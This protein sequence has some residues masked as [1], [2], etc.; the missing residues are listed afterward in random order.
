MKRIALYFIRLLLGLY[1]KLFT[2]HMFLSIQ[3]KFD[4]IYTYWISN[5]LGGI[6]E[7]SIVYYPCKLEGGGSNRI[8]IG[9]HSSI[10]SHCILGCWANYGNKQTF[11]PEISIGNH[12]SIGEY[13]HI[14][15]CN[16][17]TLGD[18]VLTGR[19]VYIGDNSHG[20]LSLE[21]ANI[22]PVKRALQ[23]KGKIVIGNNVWIGDKVTIL[24]GVSIGNNVIIGAN[25]VVTRN[26]PSNCVAVG[27]PANVVKRL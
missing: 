14:T 1:S 9:H 24:G 25:S 16:K 2:Y 12:C 5:F 4:A 13:T 23:S 6:G 19:Y 18:G 11:E 15:A 17:I 10:N 3:Q 27:I 8:I 7:N 21:E 26:I 20:G 22:P